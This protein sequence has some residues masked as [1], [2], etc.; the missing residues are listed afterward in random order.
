MPGSHAFDNPWDASSR[1]GVWDYRLLGAIVEGPGGN[2]FVK[3]AGPAKTIAANEQKFGQC[4]PWKG[5]F[6]A[7]DSDAFRYVRA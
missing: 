5:S 1:G 2:V 7:G 4:S 3:F 6:V